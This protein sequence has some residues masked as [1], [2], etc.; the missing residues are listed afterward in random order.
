MAGTWRRWP[1]AATRAARGE[2]KQR[3]GGKGRLTSGPGM[4]FLFYFLFFWAVTATRGRRRGK[5]CGGRIDGNKW[6]VD[7]SK[8]PMADDSAVLPGSRATF[9]LTAQIK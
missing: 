7:G 5:G 8:R 2:A 1:A 4:G 9:G 6:L 3:E